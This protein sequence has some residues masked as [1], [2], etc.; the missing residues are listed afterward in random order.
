MEEERK[1]ANI[2]DFSYLYY[3][4]NLF[5]VSLLKFSRWSYYTVSYKYE[6]NENVPPKI[7]LHGSALVRLRFALGKPF[8]PSSQSLW[9]L[10]YL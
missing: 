3:D 10:S 8:V 7:I 5:N 6:S 2:L 4:S 1:K 9:F